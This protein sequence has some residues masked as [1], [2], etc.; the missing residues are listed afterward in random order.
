MHSPEQGA[1]RPGAQSPPAQ[2]AR[3][4]RLSLILMSQRK[5]LPYCSGV[6]CETHPTCPVREQ[7]S[8]CWGICGSQGGGSVGGVLVINYNCGELEMAPCQL[9]N[10]VT[11]L[12][13]N[14]QVKQACAFR[15]VICH[16]SILPQR[17]GKKPHIKN[18]SKIPN[19]ILNKMFKNISY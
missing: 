18:Q 15:A 11:P 5:P 13:A 19:I 2:L 17:S 6:C 8:P 1:G 10:F 3:H 4:P 14:C 7:D 9:V 16:S 12:F